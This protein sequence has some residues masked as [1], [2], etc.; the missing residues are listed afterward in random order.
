[1]PYQVYRR[2]RGSES[3]E[4]VNDKT[5]ESKEE[6]EAAMLKAKNEEEQEIKDIPLPTDVFGP[7]QT[8]IPATEITKNENSQKNED[9]EFFIRET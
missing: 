2:D 7:G 1:M 8:N 4:L 5:Y 9:V 6:A 3:V